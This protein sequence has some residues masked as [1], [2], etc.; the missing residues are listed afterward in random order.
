MTTM[1]ITTTTRVLAIIERRKGS[2]LRSRVRLFMMG[3]IAMM[4]MALKAATTLRLPIP[5]LGNASAKA[6]KA[7]T[8]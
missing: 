4:G 3:A 1:Q 6:A 8:H 2:R 5:H 7:I